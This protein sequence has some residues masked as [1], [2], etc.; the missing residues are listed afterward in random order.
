MSGRGGGPRRWDVLHSKG[1]E[2]GKK[3]A[4]SR[5]PEPSW[6]RVAKSWEGSAPSRKEVSWGHAETP[7][8]GNHQGVRYH[9]MF[10]KPGVAA[11]DGGAS[12]SSGSWS[13]QLPPSSAESSGQPSSP[14]VTDHDAQTWGATS[15]TWSYG[16]KDSDGWEHVSEEGWE[17]PVK[18]KRWKTS[19][20]QMRPPDAK[21]YKQAPGPWTRDDEPTDYYWTQRRTHTGTSAQSSKRKRDDEGAWWRR[22]HRG[23]YDK[24][25]K[26][27]DQVEK[28]ALP[29]GWK[30]SVP[31]LMGDI[32]LAAVDRGFGVLLL[33]PTGK[34]KDPKNQF[35]QA[36]AGEPLPVDPEL[37][38]NTR[39][40]DGASAA[41]NF[42]AAYPCEAC[43]KV[44]MFA[45]SICPAVTYDKSSPEAKSESNLEH[46]KA[47]VRKQTV[48]SPKEKKLV[49]TEGH[50]DTSKFH[51]IMK[52]RYMPLENAIRDMHHLEWEGLIHN[53]DPETETHLCLR[54]WEDATGERTIRRQVDPQ[55]GEEK[56]NVE[57]GIRHRI[58][59][60]RGASRSL[61]DRWVNALAHKYTTA[62][63]YEEHELARQAIR[64]LQKHQ[65]NE[66]MCKAADW[67]ASLG[68]TKTGVKLYWACMG[69]GIIALDMNCGMFRVVVQ[70]STERGQTF[71]SRGYWMCGWDWDGKLDVWQGK[72]WWGA[73]RTVKEAKK[74]GM[75][76]IAHEDGEWSK[77][78][79]WTRSD[80]HCFALQGS[81]GVMAARAFVLSAPGL[82]D[83]RFHFGQEE[84][85]EI[86]VVLIG[87]S[88]QGGTMASKYAK[89]DN[90]INVLRRLSL[91]KA[92]EDKGEEKIDKKVILDTLYH[93]S[94]EFIEWAD[95][96][97]N[98]FCG[99]ELVSG[100]S[101]DPRQAYQTMTSGAESQWKLYCEDKNLSLSKVGASLRALMP[102][103]G[104]R[105]PVLEYSEARALI[106]AVTA[107]MDV[108]PTES[109]YTHSGF[110]P[111][112][113]QVYQRWQCTDGRAR[114][115][116]VRETIERVQE[117]FMPDVS[118]ENRRWFGDDDESED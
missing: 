108:D 72:E 1:A 79:N 112:G 56:F 117:A 113:K 31:G 38:A 58:R 64:A 101:G 17:L 68:H 29:A 27:H 98:K 12:W 6:S 49:T 114:F 82:T 54:C 111:L 9:P 24:W 63:L 3:Y 95:L 73:P 84:K 28:Q 91:A 7:W 105:L 86:L 14:W 8:G 99:V 97:V 61:V 23:D 53:N 87:G 106:D 20:A 100:R 11:G 19:P 34:I 21:G 80:G 109:V 45:S 37:P 104:T 48:W 88:S 47:W 90:E 81:G 18:A 93:I 62:G 76:E 2:S 39:D 57:N 102:K 110:G 60:A 4:N 35:E 107:M 116:Q 32:T 42:T 118:G 43:G 103:E 52:Q 75:S 41:S 5:S 55:T 65:E 77:V 66:L 30:T 59:E 26:K 94:R 71:E 46:Q 74:D 89:L 92:I 25:A 36:E 115:L 85:E 70:G 50:W 10:S 40:F 78:Y 51:K 22:P 96:N 16:S 83:P 15:W 33:Q 67:N 13:R 69:C 44:Y